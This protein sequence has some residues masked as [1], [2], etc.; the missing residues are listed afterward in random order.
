MDISPE[1][2]VQFIKPPSHQAA[3]C[4]ADQHPC[5]SFHS[6]TRRISFLPDAPVFYD[7]DIALVRRRTPA[8]PVPFGQQISRTDAINPNQGSDAT[9][10]LAPGSYNL[11]YGAV[12]RR[13]LTFDFSR[14]LG[15]GIMVG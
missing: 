2:S 10:H 11:E 14:H 3:L 9:A 5:A 4:L 1:P 8:G 12:E 7:V 15:H 6:S 13:P